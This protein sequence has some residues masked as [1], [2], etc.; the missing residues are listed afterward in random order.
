LLWVCGFGNDAEPL[1]VFPEAPAL[2][3]P[4][5]ADA[6]ESADPLD[7]DEALAADAPWMT[8]AAASAL[9]VLPVV[10]DDC[11][12]PPLPPPVLSCPAATP[13]V[14]SPV[15]PELA[16]VLEL[17]PVSVT[18]IA[19]ASPLLPDCECDHEEDAAFADPEA[20]PLSV[21]DALPVSPDT[22]CAEAEPIGAIDSDVACPELPDCEADV[23]AGSLLSVTSVAYG[24]PVGE[25][26]DPDCMLSASPLLVAAA[27]PALPDF[28][29]ASALPMPPK[30]MAVAS[31]ELPDCADELCAGSFDPVLT[32]GAPEDPLLPDPFVSVAPPALPDSALASA[33]PVGASATAIAL[34]ELPECAD[35]G[36]G[37]PPGLK[38][39]VMSCGLPS[40]VA[41]W[42]SPDPACAFA[43][44]LPAIAM[45]IACPLPPEV[46][47][48]SDCPGTKLR[49]GSDP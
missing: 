14:E 46:A 6:F 33:E 48:L 24:V 10:A 22:A 12:E 30:A 17:L 35:E 40:H 11:A 8:V 20:T 3:P 37:C 41:L 5:P 27:L 7:P 1:A 43:G 26:P 15:D 18:S 32:D 9:P 21:A 45:A 25:P 2:P 13:E 39:V 31:P 47:Q 44:P 28:A 34:P 23:G 36:P 16:S 38:D 29:E 42:V 4:V 49:L 19:R